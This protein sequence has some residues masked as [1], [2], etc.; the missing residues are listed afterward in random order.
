MI[1]PLAHQRALLLPIHSG[2][3]GDYSALNLTY[4]PAVFW[5]WGHWP[6]AS[7]LFMVGSGFTLCLAWAKLVT[8]ALGLMG[9]SIEGRGL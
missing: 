3:K 5:G 9:E 2:I 7:L 1:P 8:R 4:S 6:G